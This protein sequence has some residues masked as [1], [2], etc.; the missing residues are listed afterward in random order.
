M[1]REL[2][3]EE[4]EEQGEGE[5][6]RVAGSDSD[7]LED[8]EDEDLKMPGYHNPGS[9]PTIDRREIALSILFEGPTN[10]ARY[11]ASI[12]NPVE[13]LLYQNPPHQLPTL[14][15]FISEM[16]KDPMQSWMATLSV[17]DLENAAIRAQLQAEND[18]ERLRKGKVEVED[19]ERR[20]K[21]YTQER[22]SLWSWVVISSSL[23][24]VSPSRL[25]VFCRP[26][27]SCNLNTCD[28]QWLSRKRNA[29]RLQNILPPKR[30][31]SRRS[32]T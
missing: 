21:F 27:R 19:R 25:G 29:S 11:S 26:S 17:Q 13:A 23:T 30:M 22:V 16:N 1:L 31:R 18:A 20:V 4:E 2:Q 15:Q 9:N 28:L 12:K 5:A 6:G 32:S 8:Y 3:E 7:D 10:A 14:D 24:S